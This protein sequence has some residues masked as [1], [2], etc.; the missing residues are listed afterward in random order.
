M[1]KEELIIDEKYREI[2]GG[3]VDR[4]YLNLYSDKVVD[5]SK[6]KLLYLFAIYHWSLN[7]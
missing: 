4:T 6:K 5:D 1:T 2:F 7:C 3:N